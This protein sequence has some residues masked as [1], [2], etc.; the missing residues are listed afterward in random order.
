MIQILQMQAQNQNP[1][2]DHRMQRRLHQDM[3][4]TAPSPVSRCG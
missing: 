1:A 2:Q 4:Q 3:M